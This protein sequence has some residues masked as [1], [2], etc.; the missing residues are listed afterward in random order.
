MGLQQDL[1]VKSAE[2]SQSSTTAQREKSHALWWIAAITLLGVALRLYRFSEWGLAGDE[3][4]TLRDST[5]RTRLLGPKPLIFMLN[6]YLVG[7]WTSLDETGLRI[8][9]VL[10]GALAIPAL[11]VA[12]AALVGR[13]AGLYT[14]LLLAVN[15]WHIYWSQFARYYSLVFLC[16]GLAIAAW[17]LAERKRSPRLVI[18][19]AVFSLAAVLAH[20]S[21]AVTLGGLGVWALWLLGV[22]F[23]RRPSL[24]ASKWTLGGLAILILVAIAGARYLLPILAS[25]FSMDHDWGHRGIMMLA[26]FSDGISISI[27][28]CAAAGGVL[29]LRADRELLVPLAG[30]IL[31]PAVVLGL[32]SYLVPVSN[33]Y[34]YA[35]APSIFVLAGVGLAR[36]SSAVPDRIDRS[37]A[38]VLLVSLIVAGGIPR[39]WSHY[40]DGS[41]PDIRGAAT[42]VASL[43]PASDLILADEP[44]AFRH[45]L[46]T[47]QVEPLR[48][49]PY[50]LDQAR[51][52]D[53]VEL[54]GS[55]VWL[56]EI[57]RERGGFNERAAG[58]ARRWI[59][60]NCLLE[61]SFGLP[62]L[63]YKRDRVLAY[64]CDGSRD[65]SA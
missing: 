34:L 6:H 4:Y 52:H 2:T 38:S 59:R 23:R 54:R 36:I 3:V 7:S 20:P 49:D 8:L 1:Q 28:L 62:R 32:L 33:S 29:L 46:P 58:E 56:L 50:H 61:R 60:D 45:Y 21:S 5:D 19:A 14:A 31:V 13:R 37:I 51:E 43:A 17:I 53:L 30:T 26:S 25:W 41:R 12:T 15:P 57:Q 47:H 40:R 11:Y 55:A 44:W 64:R 22:H 39:L 48:R 18:P 24:H 27:I 63:D 65:E 35:A 16:T 10:F 9:P 42:L